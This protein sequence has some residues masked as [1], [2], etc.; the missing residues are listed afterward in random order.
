MVDDEQSIRRVVTQALHKEG[1]EVIQAADGLEAEEEFKRHSPDLVVL[2]IMLPGL[3]GFELCRRWRQVSKV[4]ILI[5]SAKDDIVDKSVGFNYGAD[6]YLTKPFSPVELAL[7]VKALLRRSLEGN[8]SDSGGTILLPD[9][10]INGIEHTV[11][12]K[13]NPIELTPKEF[14]LLWFLARYPGQAFT[15]EQLFEQ[16]WQ[17]EAIGDT[18][19]VTVFIRRLREKIE[20]NSSKPRYLKTVWGVGYKFSKD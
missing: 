3:D 19:T 10:E 2:D 9:I 8:R 13:G 20:A 12:V 16:I 11:K 7:R 15:R 18:S 17:E 4:P 6:D 5:L 14:D 1:Y